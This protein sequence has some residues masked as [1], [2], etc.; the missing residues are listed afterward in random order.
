MVPGSLVNAIALA[1]LILRMNCFPTMPKLIW[2]CGLCVLSCVPS[3][4]SGEEVDKPATAEAEVVSS[5]LNVNRKQLFGFF[6]RLGWLD[7]PP[8]ESLVFFLSEDRNALLVCD[9]EGRCKTGIDLGSFT[10]VASV[11]A[12]VAIHDRENL[13]ELRYIARQFWVEYI[14]N[15][16]VG[17]NR[18]GDGQKE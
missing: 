18:I 8:L 7:G 15:V 6:E 13:Q 5:I 9:L 12:V 11:P 16:R 10:E 1:L 3:E 4:K 17:E 2:I 14:E